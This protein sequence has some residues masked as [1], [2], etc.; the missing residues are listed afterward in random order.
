LADIT[1]AVL[2]PDTAPAEDCTGVEA[3][4]EFEPT[5]LLSA[6]EL[7]ALVTGTE[8]LAELAPLERCP[9]PKSSGTPV[10]VIP[11]DERLAQPTTTISS[12]AAAVDE[13]APAEMSTVAKITRPGS[14]SMEASS[15]CEWFA[16][17]RPSRWNGM[18]PGLCN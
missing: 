6:I 17:I 3:F 2:G 4:A 7:R 15:A 18:I 5:L 9:P 16:G 14:T 11:S 10:G 1:L 8:A 13:T 12:S